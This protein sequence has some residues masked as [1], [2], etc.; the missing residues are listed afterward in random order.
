MFDIYQM[1]MMLT[2]WVALFLVMRR[3]LSEDK[4]LVR[5]INPRS[6]RSWLSFYLQ[7]FDDDFY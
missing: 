7:F 4:E 6:C 3:R 5:F 1:S 2:G